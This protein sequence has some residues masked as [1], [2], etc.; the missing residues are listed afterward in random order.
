MLISSLESGEDW[1]Y[2]FRDAV[3]FRL[4]LPG[5]GRGAQV[6]EPRPLYG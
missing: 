1:S 4:D 3:G 6:T 5:S 2:C